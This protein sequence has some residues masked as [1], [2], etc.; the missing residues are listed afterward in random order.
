MALLAFLRRRLRQL[1]PVLFGI[2]LA[3]FTVVRLVPGDPARMMLGVCATDERPAAPRPAR[4]RPAAPGA[5]PDLPARRG[6]G[7]S[8]RLARLS[9]AGG[10]G[11]RRAPAAHGLADRLRGGPVRARLRAAGDARGR[12]PRPAQR[13]GDPR[14]RH[15]DARHAGL[16][17]GS[18]S[19]DRL[20]RALARLSGRGLRRGA[21][22]ARDPRGAGSPDRGRPRRGADPFRTGQ[23]R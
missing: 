4:A 7:R 12:A 5:G 10:R 20:R 1:L 23:R 8:G 18:D 11:D 19:A 2:L 3:V 15:A 9:P 21:G 6:A 16:L 13:P 14:R 17:A 22:D